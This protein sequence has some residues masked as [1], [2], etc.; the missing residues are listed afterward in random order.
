M[1]DLVESL[2]ACEPSVAWMLA[3]AD[4]IARLRGE[5]KRVKAEA[6]RLTTLY[7]M[8]SKIIE[9]MREKSP[10]ELDVLGRP[11]TGGDSCHKCDVNYPC[12]GDRS[13]CQRGCF[14]NE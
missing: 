4:E 3:A 13:A 14:R 10:V 6:E 7:A 5:L 2:R 11:Y 1:K 12:W 8:L 9:R